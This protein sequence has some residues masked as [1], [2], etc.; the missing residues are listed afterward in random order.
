MSLKDWLS[1]GWLSKHKTSLRE[2]RK[3]K[4]I[5]GYERI[6]TVSD[7]EAKEMLDLARLLRRKAE[8]WIR[9]THPELLGDS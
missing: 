1:N 6:D 5:T 4:N 7:Q 2:I 8:N 9:E 3:K